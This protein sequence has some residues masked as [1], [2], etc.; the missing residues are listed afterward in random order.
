MKRYPFSDQIWD[1]HCWIFA[2]LPR[3]LPISLPPYLPSCASR[4]VPPNFHPFKLLSLISLSSLCRYPLP[5]SPS[6]HFLP[7]PVSPPPLSPSSL[8]PLPL[9]SPLPSSLSL[10]LST[11]VRVCGYTSLKGLLSIGYDRF[12]YLGLTPPRGKR[13]FIRL[14]K[15]VLWKGIRYGETLNITAV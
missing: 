5:L 11:Y 15:Q 7:F 14:I 1:V 10:T 13:N 6:S 9:D 12:I 8:I 4:S 2:L 3:P